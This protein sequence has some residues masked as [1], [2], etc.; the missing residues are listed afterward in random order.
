MLRSRA[1]TPLLRRF[2]CVAPEVFLNRG[3]G[4]AVDWWSF[5]IVL[6]E[7]LTGLP[8][9]Y[10]QNAQVMRKRVLNKPLAFPSYVSEEAR[11]LLRGLLHRD[12]AKRLGSRDGSL[13]IKRHSFFRSMDWQ[14]VTFREI[15]PPIQP[16]AS[17]HSIVRRVSYC[18]R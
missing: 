5:G 13:E 7:M 10:S 2:I 4:T 17:L 18:S 6:Y 14:M 3:Y 8:P 16:C 9:W 12:P 1:R 11:G 15:F